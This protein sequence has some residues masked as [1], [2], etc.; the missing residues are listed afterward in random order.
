[1]TDDDLEIIRKRPHSQWCITV[2][3]MPYERHKPCDCGVALAQDL[4]HYIDS[5]K[6]AGADLERAVES[7]GAELGGLASQYVAV[8]EIHRPM[9][10]LLAA[11]R[12]ERVDAVAG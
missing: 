12:G 6:A 3:G 9:V 7:N 1:M 8:Y 11:I 10:D 5:I 2:G 4:V